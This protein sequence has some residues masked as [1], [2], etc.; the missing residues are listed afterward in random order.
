LEIIVKEFEACMKR[1][2]EVIKN[3]KIVAT[4]YISLFCVIGDGIEQSSMMSFAGHTHR[5]GCRYCLTRGEHPNDKGTNQG[6][7]YFHL[8]NQELRDKETLTLSDDREID[9]SIM[10]YLYSYNL[11]YTY[12]FFSLRISE[13]L[14]GQYVWPQGSECFFYLGYCWLSRILFS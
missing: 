2:I 10:Y 4:S 5:Y 3:Q 9:V 8:R 13:F 1:P 12:H 6:G 7:M 11:L 14:I